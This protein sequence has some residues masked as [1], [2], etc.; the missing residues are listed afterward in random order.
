MLLERAAYDH[1]DHHIR[2]LESVWA[3][4][5]GQFCAYIFRARS[6]LL[7]LQSEIWLLGVLVYNDRSVKSSMLRTLVSHV[8]R[9]GSEPSTMRQDFR[10]HSALSTVR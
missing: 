3:D 2:V 10:P 7:F 9:L 5:P 4:T 6:G 1:R 8:S